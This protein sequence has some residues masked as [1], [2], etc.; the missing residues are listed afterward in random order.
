MTLCYKYQNQEK[1]EI[2]KKKK[3]AVK[4]K[5]LAY[6][7]K[8]KSYESGTDMNKIENDIKSIED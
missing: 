2:E 7:N 3:L 4:K 1:L 6:F 5:A 8:H